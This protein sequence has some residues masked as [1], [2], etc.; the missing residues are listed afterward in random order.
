M[1]TLRKLRNGSLQ[2]VPVREPSESQG[3]RDT[4]EKVLATGATKERE[5]LLRTGTGFGLPAPASSPLAQQDTW[6][7]A[8]LLGCLRDQDMDGGGWWRDRLGVGVRFAWGV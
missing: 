5:E 4:T 6:R 8:G 1:V 2:L 3:A 7:G